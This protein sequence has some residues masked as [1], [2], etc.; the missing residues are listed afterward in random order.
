M[1]MYNRP[2][3]PIKKNDGFIHMVEETAS[4]D[5]FD[6]NSVYRSKTFIECMNKYFDNTDK[7]TRCV[8]LSVNEADQ[9]VVITALS[10]KL[11][12]MILDKV[13]EI[14]FGT[15]PL[16]KGDIT[17]IDNYYQLVDC[18]NILS[19]LLVQYNQPTTA[20]DIVRD[21]I[22]NVKTRKDLFTKAY[23]LNV[24]LPILTYNSLVLAIVESVSYMISSCIEFI[25]L[26][27]DSGFDIALNKAGVAKSMNS[28][29]YSNLEKFNNM[30]ADGSFDKAMDYIMKENAKNFAGEG[31]LIGTAIVASMMGIILLLIPII[32][33]LIFLF[34]YSRTKVSD[35]FELQYILLSQNAY[36]IENSLTRDPKQRKEIANKQRKI[37]DRFKKV[38]NFFKVDMKTAESKVSKES[39]KINKTK[40]K[41]NDVMDT[42]PASS[43]SVLF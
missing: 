42:I 28:V 27:D 31:F 13:D 20:I 25:K 41:T 3:S 2:K 19:E 5:N 4:L 21:S 30:C 18:V 23:A 1:Y 9:N 43:N 33:E 8:L 17:K 38:S 24:E 36:N 40:Y 6:Y 15:I 10:N 34:Y 16:S 29:L 32:R 22:E 37:A 39:D 11:Y 26:P 35:Y 12:K 7:L 14:D